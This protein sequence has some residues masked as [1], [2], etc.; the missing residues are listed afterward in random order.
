MSLGSAKCNGQ[1][2]TCS[3]CQGAAVRCTYRDESAIM[4]QDIATRILRL[5]PTTQRTQLLH[6][7]ASQVTSGSARG[8]LSNI[9]T[10]P[11]QSSLMAS[12]SGVIDRSSFMFELAAQNSIAY[13]VISG[14]AESNVLLDRL[15]QPRGG[16]TA[17]PGYAMRNMA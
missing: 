5:L 4:N 14:F 11:Y 7:L 2:P 16:Q 9:T 1:R 12:N 17:N 13:P 8:S 6:L 3:Y 10:M 15:I